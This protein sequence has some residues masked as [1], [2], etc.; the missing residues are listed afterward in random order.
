MNPCIKDQII[1]DLKEDLWACQ[2][3]IKVLC[4]KL[5]GVEGEIKMINKS[6]D[7]LKLKIDEGFK[8]ISNKLL[9]AAGTFILLLLTALGTLVYTLIK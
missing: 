3:E 2:T 4:A 1:E 7:E 8:G 5:H 6:V 9:A